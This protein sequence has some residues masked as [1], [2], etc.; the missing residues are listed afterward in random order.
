[1]F[2]AQLLQ[3]VSGTTEVYSP[4]MPRGG[5]AML[6]TLDVIEVGGTSPQ[7]EVRVWTKKSEDSGNGVNSE[8]TTTTQKIQRS[9]AGRT[10]LEWS[11]EENANVD[12]LDLVRY[13]FTVTG[14]DAFV[15]FR[16]LPPVWFDAVEA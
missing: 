13:K 3:C 9:D 12:L 15:L 6:V 11:V 4:W 8:T 14:T 7:I 1:M 10:T 16:M 5:D 2:D